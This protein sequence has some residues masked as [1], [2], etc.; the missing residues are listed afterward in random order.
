MKRWE[1]TEKIQQFIDAPHILGD[2]SKGWDCLNILREVY[3]LLGKSFP[4]EFEGW[5]AE[6]YA[7]RWK[8][9]EGKAVYR[10]FLF[11]LG[12][13]VEPNYALEGDL[14]IFDGVEQLFPGIYLGRGHLLMVFAPCDTKQKNRGV[15]VV[16]LRFFKE[17]LIGV[18]RLN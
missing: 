1:F 6:N 10:D 2:P 14:F 11:S 16:P 3:T 9:G 15:K 7:E 17:F 4:T 13:P 5:N 12:Q 8:R 18:R